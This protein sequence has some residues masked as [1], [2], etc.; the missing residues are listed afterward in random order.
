MENKL[1]VQRNATLDAFYKCLKLYVL[2][3]YDHY[4]EERQIEGCDDLAILIK[5]EQYYTK[6]HEELT[7]QRLIRLST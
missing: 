4:M 6:K 2:E 5:I 3:P 1:E 7:L